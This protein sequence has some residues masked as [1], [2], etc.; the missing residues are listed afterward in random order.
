MPELGGRKRT[1]ARGFRA[2]ESQARRAGRFHQQPRGVKAPGGGGEHFGSLPFCPFFPRGARHR[3]G[4]L[5]GTMLAG[6]RPPGE[7]PTPVPACPH[8]E[9]QRPAPPFSSAVPF[10][11]AASAPRHPKGTPK[12]CSPAPSWV[13]AYHI[14]QPPGAGLEIAFEFMESM[15]SLTCEPMCGRGGCFLDEFGEA[16]VPSGPRMRHLLSPGHRLGVRRRAQTR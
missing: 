12:P 15:M 6:A 9:R 16:E 13:S 1:S 5:G 11:P 3:R 14:A 8:S 4:D 10:S 7:L 2:G